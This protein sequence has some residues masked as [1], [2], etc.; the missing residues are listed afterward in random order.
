MDEVAM[1]LPVSPLA[2]ERLP[3]LTPIAGVKLAAG[4]AGI[5]YKGR[6]DV[7]LA[8]C[9][10]GTQVA[11]VFTRSLAA[12]APID[13][14]RT[15]LAKGQPRAVLVNAGNANA[16][17]GKAGMESV[18]RSTAAVASALGI[19]PEE[20]LVAST[21][22]IG[23]PLPDAKI[24]ATVPDMAKSL[25][26]DGW[27]ESAA[28]ILTTDTFKKTARVTFDLDGTP[29]VLQGFAKG[30]GMIAPDMATMLG[31]IFTDAAIAA[32]VLQHALRAAN[33]QSF[34]AITVDSDTSTNDCAILFATGKAGNAPLTTLDD[35][36]MAA[37][38]QALNKLML[39]L[40][41]LIVRDGEGA[42]KLIEITVTGAES[43][44]AAK[45][46]ALSIGNSPLVKTAIAG[47]DA[48]WGRIVAAVG[49]AGERADRDKL[50]VW[51]GGVL[52]A[53]DGAVHPDYKEA[54]IMPHMRG[55]EIQMRVDVGIGAGSFTAYSCDFTEGY[56]RING[57]Y[58]S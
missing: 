25:R 3:A 21:G 55:Q 43:A 39:E 20:V 5:R 30:S 47:Q 15:V 33:E 50:Q 8:L 12:A 2:P 49:K 44:Q 16:F 22:V 34:N 7:F 28:S 27:D 40:A 37:F 31:F 36:R 1:A 38:Q 10:E 35:P 45:R 4:H 13:W 52:V 57:S 23:E 41:V 14:C 48:N 58:R 54:E 11:G 29:V 56:I 46:I 18:L 42:S 17:T 32:P 51:I 19:A 24:T 26:A 53:A 9:D 6:P